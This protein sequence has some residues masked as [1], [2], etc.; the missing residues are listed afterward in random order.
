MPLID[1]PRRRR[2]GFTT[3]EALIGA[4]VALAA[5]ASTVVFLQ[6]QL[7]AIALQERYARSQAV[8]RT[9][10]DLLARE[11]PMAG[12][13]PRGTALPVAPGPTCPGV[14]RGIVVAE[15]RR[16]R[17]RQDLD[18]DG[19][20]KGA[21]ED[22]TYSLSGGKLVR[23]DGST[24]PLVDAVPKNGLRFRYFGAGN[25]GVELPA[26]PALGADTR[27]CIARVRVTLAASTDAAGIPTPATATVTTEV[28]IR[29]R[30][31]LRF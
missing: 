25:P 23:K 12:Y 5:L 7:K 31:L 30:A 29:N 2:A 28:S 8:T 14:S 10:V 17:F 27:D 3:L 6:T 21:G 16:L 13:D 20:I 24:L 22:V 9:A 19:A 26:E 4:A 15:R 1:A 18:G 11:L